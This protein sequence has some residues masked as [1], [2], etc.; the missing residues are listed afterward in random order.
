[1]KQVDKLVKILKIS[2]NSL[3][4]LIF[5]GMIPP[6]F[7]AAFAGDYAEATFIL[8]CLSIG[9]ETFFERKDD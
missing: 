4:L 6:L 5:L 2:R 9:S 8:L 3:L 7:K 1:M